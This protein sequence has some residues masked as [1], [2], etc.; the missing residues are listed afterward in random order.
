MEASNECGKHK[1]RNNINNTQ[2][3][4]KYQRAEIFSLTYPSGRCHPLACASTASLMPN[5][6]QVAIHS[7]THLGVFVSLTLRSSTCR[8]ITA[9]QRTTPR[10]ATPHL[11][12]RTNEPAIKMTHSRTH[13]HA[14]TPYITHSTTPNSHR[15]Q[16][17]NRQQRAA[18]D[19]AATTTS[20]DDERTTN[21]RTT[22]ERT[23]NERRTTTTHRKEA[24]ERTNERTNER[25]RE[26]ERGREGWPLTDSFDRPPHPSYS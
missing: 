25:R 9:T 21:E 20:N 24:D 11:A 10:H 4:K 14:R 12:Q 7:V 26:G 17:S 18:T 5:G 3:H 23:T 1:A 13:T 6:P 19:T 16:D 15:T 2:L 22:N 8:R